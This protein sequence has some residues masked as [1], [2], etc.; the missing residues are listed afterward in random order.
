MSIQHREFLDRS[1]PVAG[2]MSLR[3]MYAFKKF[4]W[5]RTPEDVRYVAELFRAYPIEDAQYEPMRV[6][7][8][9]EVTRL[10]LP[11]PDVPARRVSNDRVG[12][13]T[14][15][16][17]TIVRHGWMW[18]LIHADFWHGLHLHHG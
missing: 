6:A 14:R 15:P 12:R 10:G 17:S 7:F 8:L 9:A 2:G 3:D 16:H 4:A 5:L 13:N 11:F 18:R 1:A